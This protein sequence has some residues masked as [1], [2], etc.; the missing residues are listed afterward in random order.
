MYASRP[1]P[2]RCGLAPRQ[3]ARVGR[4]LPGRARR[5]PLPERRRRHVE[6]PQLLQQPFDPRR[7]G[8]GVDAVDGGDAAVDQELG[9]PLVGEDHQPLD[10]PV[11]LGLR[12]PVGGDDVAVGVELELRLGRF[13]VEAGSAAVLAERGGDVAGRGE[14]FGDLAGGSSR[15]SK[16]R[17]S[18]S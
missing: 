8:L 13:D 2:R 5:E 17:S 7:V 4:H 3:P 15:P 6:R 10:Q 12:H 1:C 16:T 11:G 14:R 18:W 9:D